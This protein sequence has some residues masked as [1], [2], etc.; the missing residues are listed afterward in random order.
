[1]RFFDFIFTIEISSD[2]WVQNT[3]INTEDGTR[4]LTKSNVYENDTNA[5]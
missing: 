1:V 4:R 5:T 2:G 3:P